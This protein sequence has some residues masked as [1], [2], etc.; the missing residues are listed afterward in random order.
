MKR[1]ATDAVFVVHAGAVLAGFGALIVLA[2]AVLSAE[3][4]LRRK[5]GKSGKSR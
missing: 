4:W 1:L 2:P 5:F 3:L